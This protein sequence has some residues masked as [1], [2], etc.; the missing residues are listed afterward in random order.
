VA[1]IA[2]ISYFN[3]LVNLNG[4]KLMPRKIININKMLKLVN[5]GM[6]Q[7]EIA[8]QLDVTPAAVCKKLK[9]V[10]GQNTRV[11]VAKKLN[12]ATNAQIDAIDQLNKINQHTHELL[13]QVEDDPLTSIKIIG[14]IRQQL[15]LQI[16]IF[17]TIFNLQAANDFMS[18]VMEALEEVEPDVRDRVIQK[19]NSKSAIRSALTLR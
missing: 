7:A 10:K 14:E 17:E 2:V 19:L 5:A 8:R 12:R 9:E 3:K 11:I 15:K 13:N 1:L 6:S 16:E 4:T 18:S